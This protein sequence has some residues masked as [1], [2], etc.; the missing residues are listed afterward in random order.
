MTAPDAVR[1]VIVSGGVNDPSS[2]RL[3]A[4]RIAAKL[5][6]T[7]GEG[8]RNAGIEAV[9]LGPIAGEI[10]GALVGGVPAAR[11][12]EALAAVSRADVLVAA[13]PIYKAGVSGLFKSFVDL[14]DNDLLVGK[15]VVP[16]ATAGSARHAMVVD[17]HLRPLFAFLRA[18]TVP[19]AVFAEP[20]DWG[21][22]ALGRRIERAAV[23]AAALLHADVEAEV[24]RRAW[25]SYQ[26]AFGS[27]AA[28]AGSADE[29]DFDTPLM[30]L[31]AGGA[32][33]Q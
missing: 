5:A 28:H 8:G 7:I 24:V 11:L 29:I 26:H 12:E 22:A 16:A 10:A 20:A 32:T 25:G 1:I 17:D 2:T 9:D 3:L 21:D 31:A 27:S 14:M 33:D 13:T 6:D 15:V 23:E 19:T 18:V 4:D 30:R